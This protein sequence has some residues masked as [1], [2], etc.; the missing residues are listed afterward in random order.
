MCKKLIQTGLKQALPALPPIKPFSAHNRK[1]FLKKIV[2]DLKKS[3]DTL[4]LTS[5]D[6]QLFATAA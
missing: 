1:H 5:E 6:F 2:T 4:D 3:L